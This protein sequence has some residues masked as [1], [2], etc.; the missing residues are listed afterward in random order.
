MER[1]WESLFIEEAKSCGHSEQYIQLCLDYASTLKNNNLPVIFDVEHLLDYYWKGQFPRANACCQ[2]D[3]AYRNYPIQ[4]K[5]GGLRKISAPNPTLKW[6]QH[7]I[8]HNILEHVVGRLSSSVH[9]FVQNRSIQTN[10][11]PHV[12]SEWIINIDLKDYFDSIPQ[13]KVLDFFLQLGYED[14]V[15]EFL[16]NVCTKFSCVTYQ[17]AL[18]QG[19]PTSPLLANFLTINLDKDLERL[20]QELDMRYTRYADDI[21]FSGLQKSSPIT[22]RSIED[23][24]YKHGFRPNKS[25]TRIRY[26]GR[27]MMVTGLT[28]GNGVHVPKEYRK[29]IFRELHFAKKYGPFDHCQRVDNDKG[30]FREWL[31]GRIMFVR[32]IDK[33]SGDKM[34]TL[35]NNI[36][37]LI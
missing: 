15:S 34:L 23:I 5:T 18:P 21:T 3:W 12:N 9:G 8:Q 20:A 24:I 30:Y 16:S 19:A 4:K 26:K 33:K 32:S 28:V 27:K 22:P 10:A 31:L 37:W 11:L 13:K 36:N 7:W 17:K 6:C 1:T 2:F 25:K 14:S 29:Q 35:F